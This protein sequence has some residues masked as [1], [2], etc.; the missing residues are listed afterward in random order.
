M[1]V[2][3]GA[4]EYWM[5]N[6]IVTI[7]GSYPINANAVCVVLVR[8][9]RP[10]LRLFPSDDA[11]PKQTVLLFLGEPPGRAVFIGLLDGAA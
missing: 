11:G 6:P 2:S 9:P 10:K 7:I 8:G 3:C 5:M 1:I 4:V